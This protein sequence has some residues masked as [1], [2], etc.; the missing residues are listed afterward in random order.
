MFHLP[1]K[2]LS[3]AYST[4][5]PFSLQNADS[6][7]QAVA[8]LAFFVHGAYNLPRIPMAGPARQDEV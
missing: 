4:L 2:T 8:G 1:L 5:L 6:R 7:E 3:P